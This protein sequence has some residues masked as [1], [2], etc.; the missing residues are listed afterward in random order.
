MI[1]IPKET[2]IPTRWSDWPRSTRTWNLG[3]P[4]SEIRNFAWHLEIASHHVTTFLCFSSINRYWTSIMGQTLCQGSMMKKPQSV[5][6]ASDSLPLEASLQLASLQP[7][8]CPSY[9]SPLASSQWLPGSTRH[10]LLGIMCTFGA[11]FPFPH[12]CSF[13][14][15]HLTHILCFSTCNWCDLVY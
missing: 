2:K 4:T 14:A 5:H 3:L 15:S 11:L 8:F 6:K 1:F 12:L 13:D 7:A 9:L 10:G